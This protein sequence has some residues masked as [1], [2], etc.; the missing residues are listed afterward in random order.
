[1]QARV[2]K[3]GADARKL[4]SSVRQW[5]SAMAA[6][7]PVSGENTFPLWN[8]SRF[9]KELLIF[10]WA[11]SLFGHWLELAW[12]LTRWLVDNDDV[13]RPIDVTFLPLALPYGLGVVP[14]ILVTVPLIRRFKPSPLLVFVLNTILTGVVE[15]LSAAVVVAL[16]GRNQFWDYSEDPYNLNGYVCLKSASAFGVAGTVFVYFLYPTCD[17]LLRR[18]SDRVITVL[19]GTMY[20]AYALAWS[21]WLRNGEFTKLLVR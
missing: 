16:F 5:D 2:R 13:W 9:W 17:R 18:L 4:N 20:V 21:V 1:M 7:L 6:R 12:S 10:V 19:V 11:F 8:T 3:F 14:L 15:Y